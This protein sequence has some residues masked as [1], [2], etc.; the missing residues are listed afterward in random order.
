MKKKLSKQVEEE[1]QKLLEEYN[2]QHIEYGRSGAGCKKK[3]M[4]SK[5]SHC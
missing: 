3:K 4:I 1:V 2:L 5:E